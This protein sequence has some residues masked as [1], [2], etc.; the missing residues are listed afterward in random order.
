MSKFTKF[1]TLLETAFSHYSNGGFREGTP[2]RLKKSFLK[3]AYFQSHYSG[4]EIFTNWITDLIER[5][6]FFF[7]KRIVGHGSMQDVKDANDNEGAGKAYLLLRVDPRTLSVPTELAEFTVPADFSVVEV[8]HFGNNLP[9]VQGV[10][11][12]YEKPIG[13]QKPQPVKIEINIGNQPTD[14]DL[15]SANTAIPASPAQKAVFKSA[16]P[17]KRTRK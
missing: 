9:P 14:K 8:L 6:Y 7:I 4:D 16:I 2:I 12:K 5:G 17:Y 13:D 1:E 3:H 11:N 15:A 10:P